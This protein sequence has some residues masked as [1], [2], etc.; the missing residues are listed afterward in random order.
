M[1]HKSTT[2][3]LLALLSCILRAG[4]VH[5]VPSTH[6]VPPAHL[7]RADLRFAFGSCSRHDQVQTV[8][9]AVRGIAPDAFV[10]LGD[11]IYADKKV[12]R[13]RVY[14]GNEEH[15]NAFKTQ[16][17]HEGYKKL[18]EETQ[19]LGTWDD[20]D[21]GFNNAGAD[22]EEKSFAKEVFLDFLGEGK[23]S[24]R[25]QRQGV[26]AHHT[27]RGLG[28]HANRSARLI[29]LDTRF[30]Q[31][32]EK[33]ELLGDDQWVWLETAL[34][35]GVTGSGEEDVKQTTEPFIQSE[36]DNLPVDVTIVGSSIQVHAETQKVVD[37]LLSGVE[38]WNEFPDEKR[39]LMSLIE[40]SK[41]R[42]VFLSGDVHHAEIITSPERC[43]L[44]YELVEITSSG[45]THG[46][47]DEVPKKFGLRTLFGV[48][49]PDFLPPWL[50]PDV[51]PLRRTRFIQR[52]FGEV[53]ID[54]SDDGTYHATDKQ[55]NGDP[56]SPSPASSVSDAKK[57][58]SVTGLIVLNIR[59][60]D[61]V[62]KM[63]KRIPLAHLEGSWS[64]VDLSYERGE[65]AFGAA[66]GRMRPECK[67]EKDLTWAQRQRLPV[68]ATVCLIGQP[69]VFIFGVL[70]LVK[71]LKRLGKANPERKSKSS[72]RKEA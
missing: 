54:F 33:G 14:I 6:V 50:W 13:T 36:Q 52:N 32:L 16:S 9:G 4:T 25:R 28:T 41:Q 7:D 67:T 11:V 34:G 64:D 38:S 71:E 26:Y 17:N 39:R 43:V 48:L 57:K 2:L 60:D 3:C 63:T 42:V 8:W 62:V 69:V 56:H 15:G 1:T 37:G 61:N 70:R 27:F 40:R 18:V 19:I 53:A 30:H 44:P 23:D 51:G 47:L 29:L 10:W 5:G 46:I 20:H 72:K 65:L 31:R 59:G 68:L 66:E 24:P 35:V 45:M 21:F 12:N 55:P 22:W 58:H 49:L